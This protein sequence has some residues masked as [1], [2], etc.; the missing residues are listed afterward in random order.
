MPRRIASKSPRIKVWPPRYENGVPTPEIRQ[1]VEDIRLCEGLV[2]MFNEL[3]KMDLTIKWNNNAQAVEAFITEDGEI[4]AP[5][6]HP[7]RKELVKHE[8]AHPVFGSDFD[9][10]KAFL[11]YM[12]NYLD[13]FGRL[14][15]STKKAL[16]EDIA[17][18]HLSLIHI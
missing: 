16:R 4:N 17:Y 18:I 11:D 14:P 13:P 10:I 8:L 6:M 9:K 12:G 3:V 7:N 2:E 15:E 1:M 5:K